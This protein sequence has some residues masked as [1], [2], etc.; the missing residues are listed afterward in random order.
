MGTPVFR[1]LIEEEPGPASKAGWDNFKGVSRPR[2]R[3]TV[4]ARPRTWDETMDFHSPPKVA[5]G[6]WALVIVLDKS[7][8]HGRCGF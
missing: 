1:E 8:W 2:A 5:V 4:S 3:R 7:R 6:F